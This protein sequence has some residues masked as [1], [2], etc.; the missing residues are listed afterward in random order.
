[1]AEEWV[2]LYLL[3]WAS[4]LLSVHLVYGHHY[5]HVDLDDFASFG[6]YGLGLLISIGA[7]LDAPSGKS[8]TAT[9]GYN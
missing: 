5:H 7:C 8:T 2:E 3:L 9:T 6:F 4:G 1:V